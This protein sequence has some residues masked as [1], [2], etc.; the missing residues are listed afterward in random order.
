MARKLKILQWNTRSLGTSIN[1]LQQILNDNSINPDIIC[2]QETWFKNNQYKTIAGYKTPYCQSRQT[3]AGGVAIYVREGIAS[4]VLKFQTGQLEVVGARIIG[5]N[6]KIDILNCYLP[7]Q[8]PAS[9]LDINKLLKIHKLSKNIILLG[10]LNAH[11]L[12]WSPYATTSN[13][14]KKGKIIEA[15]LEES[16]NIMMNDGSIT[17]VNMS[18][19]SYSGTSPDITIL[20]PN[21]A[22]GASWS[23]Y[24]S[25]LSSDHFPIIT[26]LY[27][28]FYHEDNKQIPKWKFSKANWKTFKTKCAEDLNFD[29]HDNINNAT[30]Q[31]TDNLYN[32]AAEC[33]PR[34]KGGGAKYNYNPWWTDECTEAVKDRENKHR[35]WK[36]ENK[37][38]PKIKSQTKEKYKESRDTCKE[39][40]NKAKQDGW[41]KYVS[42]LK[43]DTPLKQVW[44]TLRSFNGKRIS[45]IESLKLNNKDAHT[46]IDKANLLVSHYSSMSSND[47]LAAH[48]KDHKSK[49]EKVIEEIEQKQTLNNEINNSSNLNKEFSYNELIAALRKK[50][51]T[52]PGADQIHYTILK[53]LPSQ[54]KQILL[55]LINKSWVDGTLPDQWKEATV[56]PIL[57]ANKNHNMPS[58]YR[59]ISLTSAICK[60]METMIGQRLTN[61]LEKNELLAATQSGFRQNRS[62]IDQI[63]RLETEIKSAFMKG[64]CLLAIFLDLEKAFDLMWSKG[65]ILKLHEYGITNRMIKWISHF[66]NG[67]KIRVRVGIQHSKLND[68]D[69]GCPQGSVLSPILFNVIINT[70]YEALKDTNNSLSQFADDSAIWKNSKEPNIAINH[71]NKALETIDKW[72]KEWGF[73]LS[74]GK[75][76]A[77]IFSK[78]LNFNKDTNQ[79]E[80]PLKSKD[81]KN[82]HGKDIKVIKLG[83]SAIPYVEVTTFLGMTLDRK[84]TW[85]AHIDKL[86]MQCQQRLNVL[87][88]A[89]GTNFGAD[90]ITLVNLYKALILSKLDYGSQ[91][92]HSATKSDLDKINRIQAQALRI[93]TQT[94]HSTNTSSLEVECSVKPLPLRREENILKYWARSKS[95][96]NKLPINNLVD[97]MPHYENQKD[98]NSK[99]TRNK[100]SCYAM[101]ALQLSR[102]L[103]INEMEFQS[104]IQPDFSAEH[105]ISPMSDLTETIKKKET[106]K[107]KA[108]ELTLKHVQHLWSEHVQIFTDGSKHEVN[109]T[110]AA[111]VIP[112]INYTERYKLHK[113]LTIFSAELIAIQKAL[114]WIEANDV[115]KSVILTDSLSA[116]QTIKTGITKTRQNVMEDIKKSINN[117][118]SNNSTVD[119]DWVPS[120]IDLQGNEL[121]DQAANEAHF[122][123][124]LDSNLPTPYEIYATIKAKTKQKWQDQWSKGTDNN[125]KRFCPKISPKIVQY[126]NVRKVDTAITRLRLNRT[127]LRAS[128]TQKIK[129]IDPKCLN[130]TLN[131][132]E[133]IQHYLFE[134]PNHLDERQ[135]LEHTCLKLNIIGNV[136]NIIYPTNETRI[137]IYNSLWKYITET[138]YENKI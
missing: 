67:R 6:N 125:Y 43:H 56:I 112:E 68:L 15:F 123:G 126:S 14:C 16:N 47:N 104:P 17:R 92:Y 76:A 30:K 29:I 120:H 44:D 21:L 26:T 131:K 75:T 121:A 51:S 129:K 111:F 52:A 48:F 4:E 63:V 69:N 22:I 133:T 105:V 136:Q 61:H 108:K 84:L 101:T 53:E 49:M 119:I 57:K 91:A 77:V 137:E 94:P 27:E 32:V 13:T 70:L 128:L 85:T 93:A 55:N 7:P 127:K 114:K 86:V 88:A 100:I 36:T 42:E 138:G 124:E 113:E 83:N 78:T 31:F 28:Q 99:L 50:K 134:C 25:T 39:T 135:Q 132:D 45:P 19:P 2:L 46:N 81:K 72:Q 118:I 60:I 103:N 98:K 95:L 79:Y 116:I 33:I 71:I 62:T 66:L 96:G 1:E 82:R 122:I 10:D 11:N 35:L 90:K 3:S 24:N 18:R 87:K 74:A 80:R 20:S 110:S 54:S 115:K 106:C 89:T 12:L 109:G 34:T 107:D 58:S 59:P 38:S 5:K 41:K 8:S 37:K 64:E 117:I 102:E 23:V 73:K 40:L 130:C 97:D 9:S 65:V